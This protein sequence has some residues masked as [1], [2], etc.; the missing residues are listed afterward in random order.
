MNINVWGVFL[1]FI[2]YYSKRKNFNKIQI[3]TKNG[4]S[5]VFGVNFAFNVGFEVHFVKVKSNSIIYCFY[6]TNVPKEVLLSGLALL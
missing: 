2:V 3:R 1:T 5:D 6:D 4:A